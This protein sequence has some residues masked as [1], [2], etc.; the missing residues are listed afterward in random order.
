VEVVL[1]PISE[2]D[3]EKLLDF[4]NT[5]FTD[6][7]QGRG[8][9]VFIGFEQ[10]VTLEEEADWL[11]SRMT[12]IEKGDLVGVVAEAS[13]RIVA[14]GNVERGHYLE[15]RHHGELG[16]TVISDHR[17]MGIGR[18]MVK[19][20]VEQ[21]KKMGLKNLEVEFLSTNQAAV[22]TYQNAGFREVGR[23]PGK[24][25]RSGKLIDSVIMARE[26]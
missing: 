15:T 4:I 18:E 16:L 2:R 3:L 19:V 13:G 9:Q 26:V 24:V 20:L 7:Q 22:H 17:G 11:A 14:N 23:I 6:K 8:S 1:R 12:Q 10:G 25:Y 21:A 5:L